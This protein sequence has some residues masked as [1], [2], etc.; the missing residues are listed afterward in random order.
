MAR[1]ERG[2]RGGVTVSDFNT[3][4]PVPGSTKA[5]TQ[6]KAIS[7][8]YEAAPTVRVVITHQEAGQTGVTDPPG[9]TSRGGKKKGWR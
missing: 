8:G 2:A 4:G 3:K 7:E 6:R 5:I 1:E 9:L